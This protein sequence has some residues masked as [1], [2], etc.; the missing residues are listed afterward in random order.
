MIAHDNE[1]GSLYMHGICS[2]VSD[3]L[4]CISKRVDDLSQNVPFR[5]KDFVNIYDMF[6]PFYFNLS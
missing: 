1:S 2:Y 3:Q 6:R 4:L 5:N